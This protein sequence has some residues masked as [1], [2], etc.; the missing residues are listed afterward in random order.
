MQSRLSQTLGS[1]NLDIVHVNKIAQYSPGIGSFRS[2][3]IFLPWDIKDAKR[4]KGKTIKCIPDKALSDGVHQNK[5]IATKWHQV[6]HHTFMQHKAI[7]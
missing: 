6:I 1:V 4:G 5:V 3:Q 2:R 7:I